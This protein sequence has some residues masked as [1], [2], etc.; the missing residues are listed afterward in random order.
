MKK[1][2]VVMLDV[3]YQLEALRIFC[4]DA[5]YHFTGAGFKPLHEWV[6]EILDPIPQ[7]VDDIKEQV[8]LRKGKDI[9]SGVEINERASFYVPKEVGKTNEEILSNLGALLSMVHQTV[10]RADVNTKGDDDLLGKIDS[11]LQKHIG[12]MSLALKKEEK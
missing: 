10:N 2:E 1:E 8:F 6:D 3:I 12:L 4:K 7:F 11:H 5:H 9:P